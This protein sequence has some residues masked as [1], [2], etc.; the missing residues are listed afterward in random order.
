MLPIEDALQVTCPADL[1]Q[2]TVDIS[3][4]NFTSVLPQSKSAS[5]GWHSRAAMKTARANCGLVGLP[6]SSASQSAKL[7]VVVGGEVVDIYRGISQTAEIYDV[8]SDSW[9][10]VWLM[11]LFS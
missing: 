7:V 8:E 11:F 1:K 3:D 10:M 6:S 2:H 9:S 5:S 4:D